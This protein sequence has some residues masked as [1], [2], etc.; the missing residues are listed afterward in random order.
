M[1]QPKTAPL[2]PKSPSLP[3]P[4]ASFSAELPRQRFALIILSMEKPFWRSEKPDCTWYD[5]CYGYSAIS[6]TPLATMTKIMRT[7]CKLGH[8]PALG[9]PAHTPP[10]KS[11][12]KVLTRISSL[13]VATV[14][15]SGVVTIFGQEVPAPVAPAPVPY[16][17]PI[18]APSPPPIDPAGGLGPLGG[19]AIGGLPSG[20]GGV[21]GVRNVGGNTNRTNPREIA[22]ANAPTPT[23]S[24][25]AI[26]RRQVVQQVQRMSL[27]G[28]GSDGTNNIGG[29]TRTLSTN[30]IIRRQV[31]QQVQ[32]ISLRGPR[33]DGTNNLGGDAGTNGVGRMNPG[34]FARQNAPAQTANAVAALPMQRVPQQ[35]QRLNL[36]VRT[37]LGGPGAAAGNGGNVV[38]AGGGIAAGNVAPPIEPNAVPLGN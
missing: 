29:P 7:S 5:W 10:L 14:L 36:R 2:N 9:V 23:S 22:R 27:R 18:G 13:M 17:G 19:G 12:R 11:G 20:G 25:N 8:C 1:R 31:V 28:P 4:M 37:P 32:R 15:L 35:V 30:A 38:P 21:G 26:V 3:T 6:R 16:W 34:L 24:T 33:S